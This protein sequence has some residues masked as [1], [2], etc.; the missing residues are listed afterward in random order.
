M[1]LMRVFEPANAVELAEARMLLEASGIHY[2]VEGENY[3]AAGGG[4]I[5][6][7]DTPVWIQVDESDVE[8]ARELLR[9]KAGS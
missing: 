4:F 9:K 8:S 1:A 2:F 3:F 5:S 6:H 7:G